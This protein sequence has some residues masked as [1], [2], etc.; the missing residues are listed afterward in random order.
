[1][2]SQ[3]VVTSQ[4]RPLRGIYLAGFA[5]AVLVVGTLALLNTALASSARRRARAT[6][7]PLST[8]PYA[9]L[10][11]AWVRDGKSVI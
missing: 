9:R 5:A 1:V 11:F 8:R 10:G 6:T 4:D 2:P 3:L 7:A